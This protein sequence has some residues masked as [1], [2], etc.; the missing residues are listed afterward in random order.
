MELY[1]DDDKCICQLCGKSFKIMTSTHLA[2]DHQTTMKE[3]R[4]TFPDAPLV[5]KGLKRNVQKTIPLDTIEVS[6]KSNNQVIEELIETRLPPTLK[7][8]FKS[9]YADPSNS[10]HEEKLR[11]LDF[12]IEKFPDVQ[13][14]Y[15]YEGR[16][17]SDII[18]F[19]IMT[20]I[21]IPSKMVD[22]EFPKSF[23]HNIDY[24]RPDGVR[25][26]IMKQ[27]GWNLIIID[28]LHPSVE[29]VESEL[30]KLNLI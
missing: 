16:T 20:D 26:P 24:C 19:I 7:P 23:W 5:Y 10:I 14:N 12:L 25:N 30:K 28:S 29:E 15:R 4:E 2:K 8:K 9:K 27:N 1:T 21:A 11:I 13:N 3:Y 6:P 17:K 18:E 22:F